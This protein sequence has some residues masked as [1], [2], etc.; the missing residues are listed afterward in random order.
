MYYILKPAR[1]ATGREWQALFLVC[2]AF[3]EDQISYNLAIIRRTVDKHIENLY[4][5]LDTKKREDLLR[6]AVKLKWG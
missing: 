6:K 4:N 3:T 1:Q 2:N 5:I